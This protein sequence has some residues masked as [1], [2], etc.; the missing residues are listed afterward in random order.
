MLRLDFG[1]QRIFPAV[2]LL[3]SSGIPRLDAEAIALLEAA[4]RFVSPPETIQGQNFSLDFPVHY[5][6]G[7]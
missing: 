4:V 7:D 5:S 2:E 6:S 3:K 1:E